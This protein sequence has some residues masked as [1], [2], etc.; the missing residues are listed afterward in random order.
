MITTVWTNKFT[1]SLDDL[2]RITFS[3]MHQSDTVDHTRV[4]MT[5][6]AAE[7]LAKLLMRVSAEMRAAAATQAL[8]TKAK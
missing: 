4:G 2:C 3:E 1:V 7:E 6:V 8:E 5:L